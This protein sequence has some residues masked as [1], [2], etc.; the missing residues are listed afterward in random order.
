MKNIKKQRRIQIIVMTFVSL[1]LATTLIGY[2]MKDGINFFK[3]PS[4]VVTTPPSPTETFRLGGMVEEGS[5]V[6]GEGEVVRFTVTDFKNSVTVSYAG[7]LPDLFGEGQGVVSQGKLIDGVFVASEVLARHD[8]KYIDSNVLT[9]L[10]EAG[11]VKKMSDGSYVW[12]E[13]GEPL[14]Q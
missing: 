11:T 6:R 10:E 9:T 5:I 3:S 12:V 13:S 4:E 14:H 7:I 2:A 1:A 8:E